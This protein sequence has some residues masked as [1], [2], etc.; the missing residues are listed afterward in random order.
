MN[1]YSSWLPLSLSNLTIDQRLSLVRKAI[2]LFLIIGMLLS[3]N[4]WKADRFFPLAPFVHGLNEGSTPL[5]SLLLTVLA[6]SLMG[7]VFSNKT[8]FIRIALC[9][10]SCYKINSGGNHGSIA[11]CFYSFHSLYPLAKDNPFLR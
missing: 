3:F 7:G 1:S 11:I 10:L 9:V 8:T 4:L 5:N 6:L 2:C